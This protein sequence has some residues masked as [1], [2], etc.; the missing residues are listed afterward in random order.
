[1]SLHKALLMIIICIAPFN[2]MSDVLL[3]DRL[4]NEAPNS[5]A[6][7]LRPIKGLTMKQVSEQFGQAEKIA[8]AIGK[9]PITRWHY[10]KFTVYFEHNFVIHSVLNKPPI[11]K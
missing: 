4:N 9:P 5:E 10:A 11:K 1:M 3:I 2:V 6:G 8:P 7:V